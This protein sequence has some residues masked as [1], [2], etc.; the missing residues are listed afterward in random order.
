MEPGWTTAGLWTAVLASGIYHGINPGM[1]WPLAVSA[2]LMGRGRRD[3][4]LALGPLA[5]GHFLAMAG[6]LMPFAVLTLLVDWERP[7]RLGAGV[8]VTVAGLVLLVRRR[9]PRFIARIPPTRLVFWSFAVAVAHGAGL[10]LVPIYLGL[11]STQDTGHQAASILMATGFTTALTVSA[12]H[13]LAMIASGGLAALAVHEWL[14]L[15]FIS[16]SWFNLDVVWAGSLVLVGVVS[17]G[18]VVVG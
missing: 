9:H 5:I 11:C 3:L 14:G 18:S 17:V 6:V 2:G 8:L 15:R 7:I 12:A 16:R 13:T 1:G 4:A 10:M